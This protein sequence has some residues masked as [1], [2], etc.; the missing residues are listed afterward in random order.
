MSM[1]CSF[2]G[3]LLPLYTCENNYEL[4]ALNKFIFIIIFIFIE[5]AGN[6]VGYVNSLHHI[7]FYII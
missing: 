5:L 3:I 6:S 1:R 2:I 4:N 7:M